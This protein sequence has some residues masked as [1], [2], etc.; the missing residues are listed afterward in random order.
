MFPFT[1]LVIYLVFIFST[2]VKYVIIYVMYLGGIMSIPYMES[3]SSSNVSSVGYNYSENTLYIEFKTGAIYKYYDVPE[4]VYLQLL[5]VSSVGSY[6]W[7][8][9][10]SI[11][12]YEQI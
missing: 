10:R 2:L 5:S 11:Y 7:S 8:D 9:I 1:Y 3:V 6:I 4:H 12:A